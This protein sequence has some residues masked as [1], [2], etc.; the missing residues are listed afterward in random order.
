MSGAAQDVAGDEPDDQ[1]HALDILAGLS[2]LGISPAL[3][4]KV[5]AALS[6]LAQHTGQHA[7]TAGG[8]G[9]GQAHGAAAASTSGR[10]PADA[11]QLSEQLKA[12]E[13]KLNMSRSIMRKLHYKN[14]GLEKELMVLKVRRGG[15]MEPHTIPHAHSRLAGCCGLLHPRP[16]PCKLPVSTSSV[17][18]ATHACRGCLPCTLPHRL[19][20][21]VAATW[22]SR[23]HPAALSACARVARSCC[24]PH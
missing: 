5:Q 9:A 15:C 22:P 23:S 8:S 24:A 14:V 19:H 2:S 12:A 3:R 13:Q 20:C 4:D 16:L 17:H 21:H 11:T 10:K 6:E 1:A 7:P 18:P